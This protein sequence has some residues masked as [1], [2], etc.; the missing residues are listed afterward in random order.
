MKKILVF[1]LLLVPA[2][3]FAAS[4]G[5]TTQQIR[6]AAPISLDLS[7]SAAPDAGVSLSVLASDAVIQVAG[8]L[9]T[10]HGG[11]GF[12][13]VTD[14]GSLFVLSSPPA[15]QTG[16][17]VNA[18]AAVG[19]V[20]AIMATG[21][22]GGWGAFFLGY[23]AD[24][25]GYGIFD[26][27]GYI[28]GMVAMGGNISVGGLPQGGDGLDVYGGNAPNGPNGGFAGDAIFGL[29]GTS[30]D[31]HYA[32]AGGMFVAG[33]VP[34]DAGA[35]WGNYGLSVEGTG[36]LAGLIGVGGPHGGQG[37]LFLGGC[38]NIQI[39]SCPEDTSFS[40]NGVEA[41]GF[42][43]TGNYGVY[44]H[45]TAGAGYDGNVGGVLA[46]AVGRAAGVNST[47]GANAG[48]G[49]IGIGG[50][51]GAGGIFTGGG[52]VG[53][54]VIANGSLSG[55][56]GIKGTGQG[57][58][59]Y[60]GGIFTGNDAGPG[61]IANS[62]G[63]NA[64]IVANGG[65]AI[66]I[67]VT[68][69]YGA[70][71]TS[72]GIYVFPGQ[73]G[74]Q[75]GIDTQGHGN[76]YGIQSTVYGNGA[77]VYAVNGG[78]GPGVV[79]QGG[80]DGGSGANG[81]AFT[82]G[83]GSTTPGRGILGTGGSGGGN[84]GVGVVG[85][86]GTGNSFGG[87]FSG[88]GTRAGVNAI[89]SGTNCDG[90]DSAASGTGYGVESS[91]QSGSSLY[92]SSVSGHGV[93]I[94]GNTTVAPLYIHP[95]TAPADATNSGSIYYDTT[96]KSPMYSN[97]TA[98]QRVPKC[99]H[100]AFSSSLTSPGVSVESGSTYCIATDTAHTYSSQCAISASTITITSGTSNSDTWAYCYF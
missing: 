56:V 93:E 98:Y 20:A 67:L 34:A 75:D 68:G 51:G 79:S 45:G 88:S 74:D 63:D 41:N 59:N 97:G 96:L 31:G 36:G 91:S 35:Q 37:G 64:A 84:G 8:V 76:G 62:L 83:S 12:S 23:G 44:A 72:P 33:V 57:G 53:T 77:S 1:L 73:V 30:P 28:D 99:G 13:L 86:G 54:G 6:T 52:P 5:L 66:G 49:V 3:L 47:G 15:V 40:G 18:Q 10:R 87:S 25:G 39:G 22:D 16:V 29:G 32:A 19:S 92:A 9:D 38:D 80:S 81:G 61:L 43:G 26:P 50:D 4:T 46:V 17:A 89:C 94:S 48:P 42:G 69:G 27:T 21:A 11:T 82:G 85:V 60:A 71:G 2:Y 70:S 14:G 100:V 58:G 78:T 7:N 95:S 55:G 65:N 24:G 90:V